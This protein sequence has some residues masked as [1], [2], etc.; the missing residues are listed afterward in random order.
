MT[1]PAQLAFTLT[2][3]L[4]IQGKPDLDQIAGRIGLRIREIDAEGFE[5]TLVRA[6][7]APKGIIGVARSIRETSRRRFTIAHEIAHYLIPSHRNLPN[8]CESDAVES[9]KKGLAQPELEANEFAVEFLL[10]ARLVRG[11]LELNDPSFSAIRRVANEYEA[12]LSAT[13]SRFVSLTDL[14]CVVVWSEN[15]K[16]RWW[17]KSE[18]FP[19]YFSKESIP[20]EGS[21]AYRLFEGGTAPNDFGEV[22]AGAWLE[23]PEAEKTARVFEHS[24]QFSNYAAV[25]TLLWFHL[26]DLPT[27]DDDLLRELEPEDFTVHRKRWPR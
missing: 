12:S 6:L 9:W 19:F 3:R 7:D 13:T 23:R 15:K 4:G 8:V 22:P 26:R 16:A 18:A 21:F 2:E 1:S 24:I 11:P 10:P 25:L 20:S 17:R 27:D 5:G 14:P